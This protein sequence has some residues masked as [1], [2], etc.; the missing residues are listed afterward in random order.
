MLLT[1]VYVEGMYLTTAYVIVVG[2]NVIS[3][4]VVPVKSRQHHAHPR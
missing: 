2:T 3:V 1:A 4:A